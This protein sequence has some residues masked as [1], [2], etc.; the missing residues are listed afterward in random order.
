MLEIEVVTR[1]RIAFSFHRPD[2]P[3]KV[4]DE[5]AVWDTVSRYAGEQMRLM[6][7]VS[8]TEFV[9]GH[10]MFPAFVFE[11]EDKELCVAVA[12]RVLRY[13]KRFKGFVPEA[14]YGQ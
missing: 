14:N 9:L 1:C 3:N 7:Q 13:A 4:N 11:S 5:T 12:K 8:L 10:A 6:P 2:K